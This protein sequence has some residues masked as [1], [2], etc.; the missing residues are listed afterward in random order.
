VTEPRP[1][2]DVVIRPARPE[3][4]TSI[5]DY[6]QDT[7]SWGD[8]VLDRF[9][10]WLT[11][12][13]S[14]LMVATRGVGPPLAMARVVQLSPREIWMHAA[15]VHPDHRRQGLGLS[16]NRAGLE[17]G[18]ERGAVVARL[19]IEDWNEAAQQQVAKAGYRQVATWF[20]ADQ[21]LGGDP[22]PGG[23]RYVSSEPLRPAPAPEVEGAYASWSTSE[24][25]VAGHGLFPIGWTMRQMGVGDLAGAAGQRTL[26]EGPPGWVVVQ[27]TGE[28]FV[29]V[30]WMMAT[31]EEADI[32]VETLLAKL[33]ADGVGE[34]GMLLPKVPWLVAA[35]EAAGFDVHANGVWETPIP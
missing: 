33:R 7:F 26:W 29:W 13:D 3:D 10:A 16:L 11:A 9:D 1:V 23:R 27:H 5:A 30:P 17:W 24:L 32:M 12:P 20:H 31:P 25:A 6:T 28:G 2:M 14:Q 8:Y 4:K 22:R 21:I 34:I 35:A 15:R 19:L 18:R